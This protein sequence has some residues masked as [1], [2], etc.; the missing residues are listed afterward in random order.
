MIF[1]NYIELKTLYYMIL[2]LVYIYWQF[3][4]CIIYS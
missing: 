4:N 1:Y 2:I 3:L